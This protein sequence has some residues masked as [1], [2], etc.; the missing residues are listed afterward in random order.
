MKKIIYFVL[1]FLLLSV[2]S[3]SQ[4]TSKNN[5]NNNPIVIE[6]DQE[7]DQNETP[8]EDN[9]SD[10][11]EKI[12]VDSITISGVNSV[13]VGNE[14]TLTATITPSNASTTTIEWKSL[15]E[16]IATISSRGV[17]K[18]ISAG[19]TK[20][21]ATADTK[22]ISFLITVNSISNTDVDTD[23]ESVNPNNVSF[24]AQDPSNSA[25]FDTIVWSDEFNGNALD[26]TNNWK[27]EVG[28]GGWGNSELENYTAG[29]NVSVESGMMIITAKSDLT[30]TRIKTQDKRCFKYG[31][32]VAK[33]KCD[34]GT[35][36]WPAFWMLG[37]NLSEGIGWPYCGEIDIM[38][39]AN[40]DT[41]T[42][43]TCHWNDNGSDINTPYKNV[44]YGGKSNDNN[45]TNISTLNVSE[46][47]E[48]SIIWTESLIEFFVDNT[49]IM[50]MAIGDSATGLDAF[51]KEFFILFNFAM[52]G[53][54]TNV[55]NSSSF[56]NLPW[57]MYVDYVRV[58]Q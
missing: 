55:Y 22:S 27:Y 39:H 56:Q 31:K 40:S 3:C 58:Y 50:A 7:N 38:E 21:T 29:D 51:N 14:I 10:E 18:G 26:I 32:V 24:V 13:N 15:N 23:V 30:S 8:E 19:N 16:K 41:F 33:I 52:G 42:Y 48:Y 43:A 49:K 54:F 25:S 4:F 44:N 53:Q 5:Q 47:H 1:V 34:Q 12:A 20:I 6:D 36:S 28:A 2:T 9:D 11:V 35:G 46:W 37:Q 17:V 45:F 57:N